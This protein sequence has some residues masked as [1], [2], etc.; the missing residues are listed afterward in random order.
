MRRNIKC[1]QLTKQ[2]NIIVWSLGK[3]TTNGSHSTSSE[4]NSKNRKCE[5]STLKN[6]NRAFIYF[7][8]SKIRIA[9]RRIASY[10]YIYSLFP[11][12]IRFRFRFHLYTSKIIIISNYIFN[13]RFYSW[14]FCCCCCRCKNRQ[15]KIYDNDNVV[16]V[17]FISSI[18]W[19]EIT[20]FSYIIYLDIVVE[21]KYLEMK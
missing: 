12:I 18:T 11:L 17:F 2:Q 1:Q 13:E 16:V 7:S 20:P 6:Y 9:A 8:L 5:S 15:L 10:I 3:I 14:S 21:S 4:K 19:V